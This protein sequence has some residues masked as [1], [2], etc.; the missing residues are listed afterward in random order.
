M[1]GSMSK[2]IYD[3]SPTEGMKFEGPLAELKAEIEKSG[4]KVFQDMIQKLLIANKHRTTI[5]MVPSKTLEEEQLKEEQE[6]LASIKEKLT[7]AELEKIMK[8]TAD[9][10]EF[11]ATDDSPEAKAT[12][13][14]LQIGDLKREE[15]EYP[16]AV[17]ENEKDTGVTVVRHELGSTSGIVYAAFGVDLSGV[18]LDD[19]PLIP[20]FT[21]MLIETGAGE[22]DSVALSRRIGTYT[23]GVTPTTFESPVRKEGSP[24]NAASDCSRMVTKLVIKGK[25]TSDRADELFSI[26][27]L[28]LTD[29]KLDSQSKVIEMLREGKARLESSIQGSGHSFSL[30]RMRARYTAAAYLDEK[31]NGIAF[32][33]SVKEM[34]DQAE[35]DWPTLL[36]RLENLRNTILN[37]ATCRDGMFL[38]LT[39]DEN[40]MSTI[41][42]SVEKFLKELPGDANGEKLPNFYVEE[43]PWVTQ[44]N[45]ERK[46]KVPMEDEGFV[47]P[48][49]VS[50][51]GKGGVLY[52]EGEKIH[53]SV[54]VVSKFLRT[55][56]LWD[57][58]RVIGGA[59]GGFCVFAKGSGFFG[60]VSY[61]DPNLAKTID[62]YDAT[63]D[64][65]MAAADEFDKDEAAL[66]TAIIGAVGDSDGALSPDQKG[67]KQ[68]TRWIT[69]GSAE[70]RQ[71]M[72]DELIGTKPDDFRAFAER[73]RKMKDPS[74]AVISSKAAFEAAAKEGKVMKLTDVV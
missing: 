55:G 11:Q 22:Y 45:K 4:S 34:L 43:H 32:L 8:D 6:R 30:Q 24:E 33:D 66:H 10:K 37:P 2:W 38:D 40:V 29:A 74:V 27:K 56:Y 14:S 61:R 59:Y 36:A 28:I 57:Q 25:A 64:A 18:P 58:V 67:W 15:T 35:N 16:I 20:I 52:D 71:N 50:Y 46:E 23:G 21:K 70:A 51:V 17:T 65:L 39:G 47:V 60:F 42:P 48:T 49:Q 26:F 7:D 9:L 31:M 72:R 13:P 3:G 73:L 63:A 1:L 53:G 12:I 44:A 5:E 62:V 41:Q 69:N 68:F 54:S 19:I